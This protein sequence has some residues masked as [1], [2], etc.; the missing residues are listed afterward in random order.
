MVQAEARGGEHSAGEKTVLVVE[1]H[2]ET[3]DLLRSILEDE[4]YRVL[5]AFSGKEAVQV[6]RAARPNVIT[7][8]LALPDEDGW[9]VARELQSYRDTQK[10]PIIVIS[11]YTR[12]L[13]EPLRTRIARIIT[14]PFYI[15]QIVNAVQEVLS[16][17]GD[18]ELR[19]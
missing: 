19:P 4:G 2:P 3:S 16:K 15:Q 7:L 9:E 17:Q 12:E 14:K 8:D 11:A 5:V 1:D 13:E 18:G 10:I 6:A